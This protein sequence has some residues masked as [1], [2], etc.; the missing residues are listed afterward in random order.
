MNE[1]V[2]AP[3][4]KAHLVSH[5]S[6]RKYTPTLDR[7]LRSGQWSSDTTVCT[8]PEASHGY[9]IGQIRIHADMPTLTSRRAM[10]E[11]L[12]SDQV[13][14]TPALPAAPATAPSTA[15]PP[16]AAPAIAPPT[17][18]PVA[19][20]TT[21]AHPVSW[22]HSAAT[23]FGPDGIRVPITWQSSTGNLADLASCEVRE[24]VRYNPIPNPPFLW[25]PPN[26]T[27]LTVPG[28]NGAGQD[29]HSYPL[30]LKTGITN[31]RTAGTM[32][33][34]QV[35][36]HRCTGPGCSG[37]WTNF[38]GQT[39]DITRE[40][41]RQYTLEGGGFGPLLNPWRYRITKQGTGA[42]NT[43]SYSREVEIPPP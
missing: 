28:R 43:F 21:C 6:S 42:G 41:F 35:Y 22:V 2:S 14:T 30:G 38:P 13:G 20:A 3:P 18:A 11:I 9:N 32:V 40:V 37:T 16:V 1:R 7:A 34:H 31:P 8:L 17:A 19:A 5:L 27:V 39:Y 33:A 10:G 4:K 15:A 26:P 12:V 29:T 25:N 24:V 23:D 36:Q